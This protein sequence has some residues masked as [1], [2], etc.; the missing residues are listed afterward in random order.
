MHEAW[1]KDRQKFEIQALNRRNEMWVDGETQIRNEAQTL[2]EITRRENEL[3]AKCD[4]FYIKLMQ[5]YD[6]NYVE[7]RLTS[8]QDDDLRN[9]STELVTEKYQLSKIHTKY[10]R[11][12]EERDMLSELLPR[13]IYELENEILELDIKDLNDKIKAECANSTPDFGI[14]EEY[15]SQIKNMQTLK[16]Q[17]ARHMGDRVVTPTSRR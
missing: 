10:A 7:R 1:S 13:A 12:P 5:D 4:E 6:F 2:D 14:V 8:S 3:K 9:I 17:F 15:I 16:M 11:V